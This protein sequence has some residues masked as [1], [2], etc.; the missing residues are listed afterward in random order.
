MDFALRLA[1]DGRNV[2]PHISASRVSRQEALKVGKVL[3]EHSIDHVFVMN[4]D[5]DGRPTA[6]SSSL[7]LLDLLRD[8]GITFDRIG[9]VGHPEGH[10]YIPS[11]TLDQTLKDK[12]EFAEQTG[13]EMYIVTQMCF[14]P[15]AVTRWVRH[16]RSQGVNLP[17]LA[18]VPG[19]ISVDRLVGYSGACGVGDSVQLL[20]SSPELLSQD[21]S[22]GRRV[23][24]PHGF[25]AKL[26][27]ETAG[28]NDIQ[29]AYFFT[30]NAPR[31]TQEWISSVREAV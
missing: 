20:E 19:P 23:F 11:P 21:G 30:F 29:G 7:E 28:S 3:G 5:A 26:A 16:I 25:L 14:D 8:Q 12:Q 15:S 17:V 31:E 22:D 24:N 2:V 9:V 27:D 13:A 18:G 10:P 6:H 4:G 1:G